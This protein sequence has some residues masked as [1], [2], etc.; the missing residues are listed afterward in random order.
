[1]LPYLML[2]LNLLAFRQAPAGTTLH[3]RLMTAVGSY[4][5]KVGMPFSAVLIAPVM[6]NN[7]ELLPEGSILSGQIKSVR[8][9][10]LGIR[11]ETA[12]LGLEFTKVAVPNGQ[13]FP[14]FAR[15]TQ[16]DNSREHV[17]RN[18]SIQGVRS[19]SS[20]SYR[21]SGYLRTALCWEVHAQLAVWAIKTLV[22][23]V[24]EPEIYYPAGVELTLAL[25]GPVLSG[26]GEPWEPGAR[27]LTDEERTDLE[28][29]ISDMTYRTFARSPNRPS[30]LVNL[31]FVGSREQISAAF[32]AAGWTETSARPLQSRIL[33]MKAVAQSQGYR[34]AP[35]SPLF[36]NETESDM[37]WQKGLNNMAK[38]DHIRVWKQS[39]T[40]DGQEVWVGAAT[41][42]V[43]YAYFRPGQAFTHRI[44]A[45]VD[46]ERD[47][48]AHDLE[49]TSCADIV[50]W[51][52]RPEVPR[53]ARNATGDLMNTDA[54]L[55]I[56]RLNDCGSPK[57][58]TET[59]DSPPVRARG[60]KWQR[61]LRREILSA[62][63]DLLRDNI[64]WR[65]YEGIRWVVLAVR[66]HREAKAGPDRPPANTVAWS[67]FSRESVGWLW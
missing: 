46:R 15:L 52:E 25:T 17:T 50:D 63:S 18:G 24:P 47:K 9:V 37:S 62:R 64:Y 31:M 53:V 7:A 33:G 39:R 51:W 65:G 2:S 27:R 4:E 45:D 14:L 43:D 3:V 23:S 34:A 61:F 20:V 55:A 16:V 56:V 12:S 36:L 21:V 35:M 26:M 13:T 22:V 59:D 41:R 10:G 60:G 42:D 30:D 54:R 66:Q 1:M 6:V 67:P 11:H 32:T 8:R 57:L 49:F 48:I 44:E 40:W 28:P 5:S 58:S 19:T 29:L 38:R